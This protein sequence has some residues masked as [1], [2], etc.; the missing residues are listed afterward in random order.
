MKNPLV[1]IFIPAYNNPIYTQK[2]IE[3]IIKQ[4]YRPLEV[5]LLDDCSPNSLIEMYEDLNIDNTNL[6]SISYFRNN[7]NLGPDNHILGF[8]KCKG[9]YV[10]N[11]PHDDWWVED[12]FIYE[13]VELMEKDTECYLCAANSII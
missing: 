2:T 7:L 11:M 6:F 3:S 8:D 10:I 5:L 12:N 13:A 1:S 4:S 9:K